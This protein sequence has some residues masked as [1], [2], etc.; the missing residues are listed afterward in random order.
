MATT[1]K[2]MALRNEQKKIGPRRRRRLGGA[3]Q[4]CRHDVHTGGVAP[5]AHLQRPRRPAMRARSIRS[6]PAFFPSPSAKRPRPCLSFRTARRPIASPC[7]GAS[8]PTLTMPTGARCGRAPCGRSAPQIE[9]LLPQ[10]VGEIMQT[11]PQFS[12]I[13]IAGERAY[14]IAREGE[15]VDLKPRAVKIRSLTLIDASRRRRDIRHGMRQ[16]RLCARASRAISAGC[17]AAS[18]MSRR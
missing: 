8:R 12:A 7:F 17:W 2:R 15:L 14:D 4:A 9:A 1:P 11:P 10:F 6:R 5:Q 13:K 16:G 18:A 3:R